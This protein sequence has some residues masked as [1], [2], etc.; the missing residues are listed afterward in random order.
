M[1]VDFCGKVTVGRPHIASQALSFTLLLIV[2]DLRSSLAVMK[3]T[4]T[5]IF[6]AQTVLLLSSKREKKYRKFLVGKAHKSSLSIQ[7]EIF[8]SQ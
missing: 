2:Q 5:R 4:K 7:P 1:P 3:K 6:H 8:S